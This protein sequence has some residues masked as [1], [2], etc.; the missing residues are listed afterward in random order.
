MY[1]VAN[2]SLAKALLDQNNTPRSYET[3]KMKQTY[4]TLIIYEL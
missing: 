2:K 4:L 3:Y 1:S